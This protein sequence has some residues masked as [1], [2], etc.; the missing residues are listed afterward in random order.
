M[1]YKIQKDVLLLERHILQTLEFSYHIEHAFK[2]LQSLA[3][4]AFQETTSGFDAASA[5][6][7]PTDTKSPRSTIAV[8]GGSG[9]VTAAGG[10]TTTTTTT[11]ASTSTLQT[12]VDVE[13]MRTIVKTAWS[14]VIDGLRGS[15]LCLQH[16][17]RVVAAGGRTLS[18]FCCL[19]DVDLMHITRRCCAQSGSPLVCFGFCRVVKGTLVIAARL[20]GYI[21]KLGAS[22]QQQVVLCFCHQ[23]IS[24]CRFLF[25]TSKKT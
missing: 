12:P 14:L 20:V 8:D 22:S 13:S 9:T 10:S 11:T 2:Y 7:S 21:D 25:L 15:L 18:S 4:L 24:L 23:L 16:N 5:N 3:K 17:A 1:F 19:K 6:T